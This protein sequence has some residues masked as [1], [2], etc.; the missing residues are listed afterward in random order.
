V[1]SRHTVRQYRELGV[2]VRDCIDRIECSVG[3]ADSWTVKIVADRVCFSCELIA[4][5]DDGVLQASGTGFDGAV[6]GW[7]AF[8]KDLRACALAVRCGP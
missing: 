7:E 2:F 1:R 4:Q 6:A 3:R 5:L 8:Q